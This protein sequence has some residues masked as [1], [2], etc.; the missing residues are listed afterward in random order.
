M[1]AKKIMPQLWILYSLF[2]SIHV[3]SQYP[4]GQETGETH[5]I[6]GYEYA[7]NEDGEGLTY[8]AITPTTDFN[9]TTDIDSSGLSS[10]INVLHI[11]FLD[12]AGKW[13]A[14]ISH[15]FIKPPEIANADKNI[16][17]YEYVFNDG[18]G[19]QY[20]ALTP[21]QD[22]NLITDIDVSALT[23]DIN[24]LHIRFQDDSGMWS[25]MLSHI[26]IKPPE[27][28]TPDR[29]I[30]GY[31]YGFNDGTDIQYV[32]VSP[33]QDF[34]LVTDIDVNALPH[35]INVFHVRFKADDGKWSAMM[36]HIFIKPP[37]VTNP[38]RKIVGYE[39][40][41]NNE[42]YQYTSITPTDS[43]NLITDI[44]CSNLESDINTFQIRFLDDS[45]L[46]SS[47]LNHLFINPP[48]SGILTDNKLVSYEYWFDHDTSNKRTIDIDPDATDLIV[49]ELD[50]THIWRGERR[51][52]SQYKDSYGNYSLVMT[53]TITKISLP[54]AAFEADQT[55]ICVGGPVNFT[56]AGSI[57][58]DTYTWNFDDGETST[59][60][61][62]SHTFTNSGIYDVSLTV[63]DTNTDIDSVFVQTITVQDFPINTLSITGDIPACFGD[64]V[65][66]TADDPDVAY[67]WSNGETSQSIDI[68]D[69]GTYSVELYH[70][71]GA[72]C[73]I[74]SEEIEVT[75]YPEI[76][77]SI[78]IQ[79]YPLL[80]TANQTAASYQWIDCTN[81]D[82]PIDG[83]TDPTFEPTVNGDYSVAITQNGCT[84]TS[85]CQTVSTISIADH[86]IKELVQLYPNPAQ[87]YISIRSE[88]P[89]LV[90]VFNIN[91]LQVREFEM[92]AGEQSIDISNLSSGLYVY[93]VL[94][95]S[96]TWENKHS[97][98]KIV[99]Q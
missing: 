43:Y 10:D 89:I 47:M 14:I 52:H 95:Q 48:E 19:L 75:F 1:Q 3:Y 96:G 90:Q 41:F 39:Y 51:I 5:Y 49:A 24:V 9:L 69:A 82:I 35:D 67:I 20:V 16:I 8:V 81:G 57:D 28:D 58:Y 29:S 45:G 77:T 63:V 93:K 13:S 78:T 38:D 87:D 88:L 55:D 50:M 99:K 98:Y 6:I 44:D 73:S 21:S 86:A 94:V 23:S 12:D 33:A 22:F 4:T 54:I 17:G 91:G 36:S 72:A 40:A 76:D 85:D 37:E 32:P 59:E 71:S 65:T 68:V 64:I 70:T 97:I 27:I 56:D 66:L 62:I 31:E 30:I 11:R 15:I 79:E 42:S 92:Q 80:L 34:N 84:V 2:I 74:L 26:F 53:D 7:F 60:T 83:A 46:W 18:D 61:N 25:S